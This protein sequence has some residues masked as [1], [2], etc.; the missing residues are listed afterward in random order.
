M[1]RALYSFKKTHPTSLTFTQNDLFVELPMTSVDKNWYYVMDGQAVAGYVPKNYVFT[2]R[3]TAEQLR[4]H[5]DS[6]KDA[7]R[8]SSAVGEKERAEHLS[9]LEQAYVTFSA[10]GSGSGSANRIPVPD[11]SPPI[12][13]S[14]RSV[15]PKS[16][17]SE[18]SSTPPRSHSSSKKRAAPKPPVGQAASK[19]VSNPNPPLEVKVK[20]KQ[21]PSN[22][23]SNHSSRR[24]SLNDQRRGSGGGMNGQRRPSVAEPTTEQIRTH[25]R[26]LVELV[27][28]ET[29]LSHSNSQS[30]V[31]TVLQYVNLNFQ[32]LDRNVPALL[33]ELEEPV[34]ADRADF[35]ASADTLAIENLFEKLT[36][37]KDDEQQRNWMLYEDEEVIRHQLQSLS[38]GLANADPRVATHVMAKYKYFY[39]H[40]LV[41]YFQMETRWPIR[42]LLV[43]TFM[44]MCSLDPVIISLMLNSVL[45]LELAQDLFQNTESVGRLRHCAL[46]LTIVFSRGEPMPVHHFSQLGA[47]FV[48]FLLDYI[49]APPSADSEQEIPDIFIGLALAYNLQFR[50]ISTNVMI[51][52]LAG[53]AGAKTWTE[54]ILLLLNRDEDPTLI[55]GRTVDDSPFA[56][57]PSASG[58]G[59]RVHSVH[60][61]ILDMFLHDSCHQLFYTNDI[62]VLIDIIVRQLSDLGP[63]EGNRRVYSSMCRLVL[64]HSEYSDH[65]HRFKDLE[66]CFVR[67]LDEEEASKD[68]E[69]I[70]SVVNEVEA[71]ESLRE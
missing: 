22:A 38:D 4:S 10:K 53:R 20:V 19:P 67:I 18:R 2:E 8:L 52:C 66:R 50:D 62:Y 30:V 51:S 70:K 45:P 55:V 13:A 42:R 1:L 17:N 3:V 34:L 6:L 49:E 47:S 27:R 58:N 28:I 59:Q 23:S 56:D 15:S 33:T 71:F 12:I 14:P 60:K 39:V 69:I 57:P 32:R 25:A 11:S 24:G 68:K 35:A 46:L 5:I 64:L 36:K 29:G 43:E 48:S 41:E 26:D 44:L 40:N 21:T 7:I 61:V 37:A 9:N 16:A 65:L 54:K 63:E 31:H